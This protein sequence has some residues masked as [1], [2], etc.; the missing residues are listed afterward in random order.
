MYLRKWPRHFAANDQGMKRF[1][2]DGWVIDAL[3]VVFWTVVI[4]TA[5][6]FLA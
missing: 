3:I 4:M 1:L 2:H 6:H 5:A